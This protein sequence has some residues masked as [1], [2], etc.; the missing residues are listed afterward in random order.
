MTFKKKIKCLID[1]YLNICFFGP[2]DRVNPH[3]QKENKNQDAKKSI[4]AGLSIV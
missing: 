1:N 2:D 3:Y 4:F